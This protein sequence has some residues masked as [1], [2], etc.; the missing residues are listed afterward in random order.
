MAGSGAVPNALQRRHRLDGLSAIATGS[1]H[2]CMGSDHRN[3]LDLIL[4]QRQEMILIGEQ[5]HR[6]LRSF[7]RQLAV[8]GA[9]DDLRR[10][11]AVGNHLWRIEFTQPK[12]GAQHAV[13]GIVQ[14]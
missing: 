4:V 11:L 3:A 12:A 8:L 2:R 13:Q 10:D 14:T 9:A 7:E 6:I 5:H 1:E